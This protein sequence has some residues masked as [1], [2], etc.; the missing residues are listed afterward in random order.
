M[1]GPESELEIVFLPYADVCMI[2]L[3][4]LHASF[5]FISTTISTKI[6]VDELSLC[7]SV[8]EVL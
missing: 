1:N 5:K 8:S 3:F 4:K 6:C 7:H 2:F